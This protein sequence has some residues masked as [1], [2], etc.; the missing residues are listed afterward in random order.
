MAVKKSAKQQGPDLAAFFESLR[1]LAQM[2]N[3][4]YDQVIEIF[5]G[6]VLSACQKKFGLDADL[7]VILEPK[8]PEVSV[9]ARYTVVE[10]VENADRELTEVD[11]KT[12]HPD[13]AVGQTIERKEYLTDFSRIGTTNIRNIF[14]QRIKELERELVFNDYKDR[15]GELTNGQFLRWRDKEIVYVDLGKAE[16]ILPRKEQIPGDRFHPGSRIKAVIKA[17][18]LKKDKSRD[19]GPY[20]LLSRA[21]GDFVK[22]LFEQEIPEVYDGIVEILN[23]AREAGFRTKLLVRSNRMDVDPVGACVGI[24][25]VRIQSIVRE[26]QNERIDIISYKEDPAFLIAEALSPARVQEVRVDTG[27]REALVVVPDD[28]YSAAIGMA[29]KN[30]RLASQLTGY[31]LIVKSQS[32]YEQEYSSPEARARLE[33][34]FSDRKEEATSDQALDDDST[35]LSELPGLTRRV[36]EILNSA[37]INSVEELVETDESELEKIDGIGKTTA[38]LIMKIIRENI[39]FEEV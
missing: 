23:V 31:R 29:G 30:V 36:I 12:T 2:R 14:S 5:R 34:L 17:V 3:L 7:D 19:P 10:K 25:G 13:A 22:R 28:S 6:T 24:K 8:V 37:G 9:V 32:Q 11:A 26:L 39:E 35:P 16:G 4:S 21:S 33:E 18:E 1:E 20:I 27:A 38:Q 15:V